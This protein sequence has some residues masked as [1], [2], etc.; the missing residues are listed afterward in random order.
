MRGLVP[1]S[2]LIAVA[3]TGAEIIDKVAVVVERKAIT[4]RQIHEEI[5][6]SSFLNG[7]QPDFSLAQRRGAAGRLIE[8]ELIR[9]EMRA[10]GYPEA[11]P[12]EAAQMLAELR[13]RFPSQAAFR[14]AQAKQGIDGE[15]LTRR[16]EWQAAVLAFVARRFASA[17]EVESA[18][19]DAINDSFFSWLDTMRR[20][21]R[22]IYKVPDLAD[23]QDQEDRDQRRG[24]EERFN[25]RQRPERKE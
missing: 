23:P 14:Q 5:V 20:Q 11:A 8:Q 15:V 21:T 12:K 13:K 24:P 9:E 22:I 19:V 18:G 16:L 7:E 4:E 17:Q 10:S 3:L 6:Y 2:W 25:Q 1:I